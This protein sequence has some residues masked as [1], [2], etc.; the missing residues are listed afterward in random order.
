MRAALL[1]PIALTVFAAAAVAAP[2]DVPVPAPGT[3]VTLLNAMSER[4]AAEYEARRGP[5]FTA[6]R[7]AMTPAREAQRNNPGLQLMGMDEL[8][9][10]IYYLTNNLNAA[11]TISTDDVWSAPF[12]YDGSTLAAGLLGV[13]DG[14]GVRTT[15]NE[16]GGR[17]T[18]MDG[19][20]TEHFHATHV[21]GT[22]V[23]GG[24]TSSAKGMAHGAYLHAR[25]WS[26]DESEMALAAAAGM[27]ISNHSYGLATGWSYNSGD[28]NWYWYGTPG[29][30]AVE[31]YSF[32]YYGSGAE[33]WDA[34]ANN[35][36]G[37]L[38]FKSA[39]N[40]RSDTG[41]G[42]GG[43]HYAWIGGTWTWNTAT[44]DPDGG[45]T[46]YDT[47]PIK[48]TAKNI[49]VVGAVN[50]I[51]GG[52]TNPGGV[53]PASF[54]SYGPTDDGRIKPDLVANGVGL[55]SSYI[56]ADN[57]YASLSGT[58]MSSP[59][60]AGSAALVAEAYAATHGGYPDA[61]TLK[62]LLLHTTD[63][64]GTYD[65]PDYKFG[66][67]LMNT[68]S[69][70][71]TVDTA[72]FVQASLTNG[73]VDEYVYDPASGQ[74]MEVTL[75]WNDPAGNSPPAAL[76]PTDPMLVNDLD[77]RVIQGA[78]TSQPWILDPANPSAAATTG[79]NVRDNVERIEI[80]SQGTGPVTVRVTHKGSIIGAQA[81][82]LVITGVT[83]GDADWTD[84]TTVDLAGAETTYGVAWIDMD[85]D[86]DHDLYLTNYLAANVLLENDGAGGFT[87][88]TPAALADAGRGYATLFAD[89]DNDGDRDAYMTRDM[90]SNILLRNDGGTY[91]DVSSSPLNDAGA[92][93]SA[94]WVD[95]NL[96]GQLDLHLANYGTANQL[97][98]AYGPVGPNWFFFAQSGVINNADDGV[99]VTWTDY[100]NDGDADPYLTNR[101]AANNL[102]NNGLTF[103]YYDDTS[104]LLGS[105]SNSTGAAWGDYD[106]DGLMDLYIV[107]DG[108]ADILMRNN[109]AGFTYI[110]GGALG[111]TGNGAG[112]AW[113]DWDNDGDLD[114]FVARNGATDLLIRNDGG[115]FAFVNQGFPNASAN[116]TGCAFTDIDGDGDLDLFI[117]AVGGNRLI[118]NDIDNGNHWFHAD[119][120]GTV[121]NADGL[122][123]R[124]RIV[125]GGQSQY[126]ELRC[127][128]GYMAQQSST[129]E[130]GLGAA[131]TVDTLEITWPSGT[132]D[133]A[134]NLGAD[135]R[136]T[137][138]EGQVV[139]VGDAPAARALSLTAA[140]NPFNPSTELRFGLA[141]AGTVEIVI[142]DLAGRRV[143]DLVSGAEYAAG[144]HAVRWDGRDDAGR[145][146]PSGAYYAA[147]RSGDERASA[148]LML[149]K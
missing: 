78:V 32:G 98:R 112:V 115:T 120:Q 125:A 124:V 97:F 42:A 93:R 45:A 41:P 107:N 39:G 15:H 88:S 135:Q 123:A 38:I 16:F 69:A 131:T 145:A 82:S 116:S 35:A 130:F 20:G 74:P 64:A 76:D 71:E 105:T 11:R 137:F 103:G 61:S 13:W 2:T 122:G 84:V 89:F 117:A 138:V 4:F 68:R 149:V 81:Y 129:L 58:S 111:D 139:S 5:A 33:D 77:V 104:G 83:A 44:R 75:V 40:D 113:A 70:I 63:E 147:V 17:V 29:I 51:P 121:S 148:R 119:L 73:S 114:L 144:E 91:V 6:L 55:Y 142:H 136:M 18:M 54:S 25:D 46:G 37:Y 65:G 102:L 86:D 79:D 31:D 53:T 140:P 106:N 94:A 24:A 92:G 9:E 12:S 30:S 143:R 85:G 80:A 8:G 48:S 23:A 95:E 133:L 62:A 27:M 34:I 67:G 96:D 14:G 108:A 57:S 26:N 72:I 43:G 22:M 50:D 36:P 87:P 49:M 47:L 52:Y 60:A 90:E 101:A 1:V 10:P 21:A 56:G 99:E 127:G 118:R 19:A 126:R 100:D 66:W 110:S 134:V 146:L 3:D 128:E 109:G 141:A 7:D 28:G 59:S 132:V